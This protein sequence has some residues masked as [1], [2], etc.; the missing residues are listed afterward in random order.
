MSIERDVAPLT[1]ALI[2][3]GVEPLMTRHRQQSPANR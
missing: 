1:I 3:T 2:E